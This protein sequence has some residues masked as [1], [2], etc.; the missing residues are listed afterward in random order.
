VQ[1]LVH[2]ADEVN[3]EHQILAALVRRDGGVVQRFP[4]LPDLGEEAGKP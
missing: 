3:Q 1:R 4:E 2:V